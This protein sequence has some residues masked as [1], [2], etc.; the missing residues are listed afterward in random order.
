MDIN[1]H[2]HMAGFAPAQPAAAEE[3]DEQ[4]DRDKEYRL[5]QVFTDGGTLTPE[6]FDFLKRRGLIRY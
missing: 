6:E 5:C 2:L 4:E 3:M 1:I